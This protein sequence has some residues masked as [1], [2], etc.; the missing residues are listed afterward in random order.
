MHEPPQLPLEQRFLHLSC[1]A[2]FPFSSHTDGVKP[3][4]FLSPGLHSPVH[5]PAPLQTDGRGGA[6]RSH[7]PPALHVS[8]VWPAP[9]CLSPGLHM[10][11]Q[12]PPVQAA[13]QVFCTTH[14]PPT[15]HTSTSGPVAA[16]R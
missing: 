5:R 15:V 16:Q 1:G 11:L 4:H 8:G 2:H 6:P 13:G 3:S 12:A 9:H 10:P 7:S 14:P